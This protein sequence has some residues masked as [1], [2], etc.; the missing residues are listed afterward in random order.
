[1]AITQPPNYAC[2]YRARNSVREKFIPCPCKKSRLHAK[3]NTCAKSSAFYL[4]SLVR[5]KEE[6][7]L[8]GVGDD[9]VHHGP[10]DHVP[11]PVPVL[12]Q[13]GEHAGLVALLRNHKG[14]S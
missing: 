7:L 9:R 14:H 5:R 3:S 4:N 2:E 13:L 11:V 10:G 6:A 12:G 8:C 1:V